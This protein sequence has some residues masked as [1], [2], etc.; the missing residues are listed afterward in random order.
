MT[1]YLDLLFLFNFI[2]NSLFIYV[3]EIIYHERISW[4]RIFR[5]GAIGGLLILAFL[6][7]YIVYCLFKIFGG[8]IITGAAIKKRNILRMIVKSASF[9]I[10]NFASVGLV[11]SFRI[12][13]W[14]FFILASLILIFLLF[15]ENNKKTDIFINS[16]K[17][18]ISVTFNKKQIKIDG[19]L[20]TGNFSVCDGLPIIFM[21]EK[22]RPSDSYYKSFPLSTINGSVISKTYK[23]T[24]FFIEINKT[25]IKRDVLVAFTDLRGFDC[26]LNADLFIMEGGKNVKKTV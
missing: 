23:P 6:G 16:L 2:I 14:Y 8:I 25:R 4:L 9:Y 18:N 13:K 11:S 7:D 10:I 1:I 24:S 5:G 21:A 3:L 15:I 20:D 17:Y 22:Y 12:N 19:Y 26:L